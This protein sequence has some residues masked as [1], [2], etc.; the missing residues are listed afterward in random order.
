MIMVSTK[1]PNSQYRIQ[2]GVFSI[3]WSGLY[4]YSSAKTPERAKGYEANFVI[5]CA[6]PLNYI[7]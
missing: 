2:D 1:N 6:K 3:V 4:K 5:I 7:I